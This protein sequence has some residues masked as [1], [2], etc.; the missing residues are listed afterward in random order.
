MIIPARR[1]RSPEAALTFLVGVLGLDEHAVYRDAEGNM[2]HAVLRLGD[3][4]VMIGPWGRGEFDVHMIAPAETGGRETTTI[5]AV[6]DDVES[7]H[8]RAREA[9]ARIVMS[10]APQDRGGHSFSVADPE[11]HLWT[12]GDYDPKSGR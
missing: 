5:Y 3:G 8:A 2:I 12:F 9:G 10:Y 7:R 4:I 1:Y 11:G 6:V